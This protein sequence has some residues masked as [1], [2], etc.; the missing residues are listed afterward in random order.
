MKFLA[1]I[2]G[3]LS[4]TASVAAING[5]C[6]GR[7]NDESCICLDHTDCVKKWG[8]EAIPGSPGDWPCPHDGSNVWGCKIHNH[9]PHKDDSTLCVWKNRCSGRVL[10]GILALKLCKHMFLCIVWLTIGLQMLFV[11][12]VETIY[13]ATFTSLMMVSVA[14]LTVNE[15]NLTQKQPYHI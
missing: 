4:M 6:S 13:A 15:V 11:L 9:C 3:T 8:G 7:Y 1:F 14:G 10:K 2:L 5:P 12:V